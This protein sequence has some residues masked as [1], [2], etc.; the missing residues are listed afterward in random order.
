MTQQDEVAAATKLAEA[1]KSAR[2]QVTANDIA[3]A[4]HSPGVYP[5]L[6][7]YQ[8]GQVLKDPNVFP[9]LTEAETRGALSTVGYAATDIDSALAQ[10]FPVEHNVRKVGPAGVQATTFDDTSAAQSLQQPLTVIH[11][12]H[13]NIV[14]GIQA[15]YGSARTA[16]PHHG[17]NGGTATEIVLDPGDGVTQISGF[18]GGWFGGNYI[19]QL[20]IHTK[21]GKTYGPFGDM[22]YATTR[23]PFS[24]AANANE[25]TIAFFG[26]VAYGNNGQSQFLGSLGMTVSS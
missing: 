12:Q 6:T 9:A 19:L 3:Q 26:S 22:Q 1:L 11:V 20:T 25:Q 15:F 2:P 8:M 18:Y 7:A 17:G 16:L 14:D 4:L 24:L 5:N 13:G 21:Q 23:T 10:L